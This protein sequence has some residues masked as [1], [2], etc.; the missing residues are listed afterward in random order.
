MY[1]CIALNFSKEKTGHVIYMFIFNSV[2]G[3]KCNLTEGSGTHSD[4]L[5]L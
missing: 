3:I 5:L 2:G 4:L 1:K